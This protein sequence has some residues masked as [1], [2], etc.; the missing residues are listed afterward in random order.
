MRRS[1]P[2]R[3]PQLG[4]TGILLIVLAFR[5]LIP[6]GFMPSADRPLTLEICRAGF[7][8]P[9]DLPDPA[10]PPSIP[11]HFKH[12]PFGTAPVAG[13]IAYFAPLQHTLWILP[14][15]A[16]PANLLRAAQPLQRSQQP[17][18]PPVEV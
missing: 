10:Q 4:I 11:S 7:L 17:R 5:A 12:S 1:P 18:A 8:A 3:R 2:Q 6:V 16:A 15:L 14:Q 13:P 9:I